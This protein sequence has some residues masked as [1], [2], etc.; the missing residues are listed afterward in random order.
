MKRFLQSLSVFLVTS[1]S[2]AQQASVTDRD[3]WQEYHESYPV[4]NNA[5]KNEVRS[6][7]I[8]D[9]SNIWIATVEGILRRKPA[10]T[11]WESQEN[12]RRRNTLSYFGPQR[13]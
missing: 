11:S 3:F 12:S 6:I 13:F 7:S 10:D 1:Y 4:S 9:Q 5:V 2:Y 8:D